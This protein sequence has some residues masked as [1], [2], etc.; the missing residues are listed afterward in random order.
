M[1][2]KF[3]GYEIF[4]SYGENKFYEK[5]GQKDVRRS[6]KKISVVPAFFK[7]RVV[8]WIESRQK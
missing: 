4:Y 8:L 5:I 3:G 2:L 6:L 7:I 1:A